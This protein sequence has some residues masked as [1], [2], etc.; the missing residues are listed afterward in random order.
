MPR[1]RTLPLLLSIL[2]AAVPASAS[3]RTETAVLAGGC[4]WGV[5]GVFEH[6]RGVKDVVSGYAGGTRATANY[7]DVSSERTGHAEAVRIT[8]DPDIIRYSE[9]LK[10]YAAVAHNPGELNRQGPDEGTSY[11]S[12]V[13]PQ[14]AEQRAVAQRFL[15]ALSQR[16]KVVTKIETGAFFPAEA[17]HQDFLRRNPRHSYIVRWDMPKLAALKKAYPSY[18]RG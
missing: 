6:V 18:W 17:E 15:A 1:T 4:F 5:E 2:L 11:R 14:S 12:A 13:F 16:R 3:A 7:R 9:L 10:I 8:Y